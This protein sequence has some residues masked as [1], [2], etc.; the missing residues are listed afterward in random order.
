MAARPP[1]F[2]K[3]E[4]SHARAVRVRRRSRSRR[5][6]A[7]IR[8]TSHRHRPSIQPRSH[9]HERRSQTATCPA[10]RC[11]AAPGAV[12]SISD[13]FARLGE[14]VGQAGL[15]RSR[16]TMLALF[17]DDP[18]VTPEAELRSDAGNVVV[19][20]GLTLPAS[21][22]EHRLPA[23]A[24]RPARDSSAPTNSW[25]TLGRASWANGYHSAANAWQ[26][27]RASRSI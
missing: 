12:Q 24:L 8:S 9:D 22:D 23:W 21:L 10:R 15:V 14:I 13:A 11:G 2:V 20:E 17:H 3:L 4:R 26:K 19:P 7:F 1:N 6:L 18:E 5:V 16:P 27:A 25:A